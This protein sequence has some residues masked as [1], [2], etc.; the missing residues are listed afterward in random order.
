MTRKIQIILTKKLLPNLVNLY[1]LKKILKQPKLMDLE[2][3]FPMWIV[4]IGPPRWS[5]IAAALRGYSAASYG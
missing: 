5:P 3:F 2:K 4:G 1:P